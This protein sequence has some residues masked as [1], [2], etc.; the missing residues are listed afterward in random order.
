MNFRTLARTSCSVSSPSSAPSVRLICSCF[1][2]SSSLAAL[3]GSL[4]GSFAV[5]ALPVGSGVP[6]AGVVAR[7]E[8]SPR[9]KGVSNPDALA[10]ESSVQ[11]KGTYLSQW[12]GLQWAVAG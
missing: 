11:E 4:A 5:S 10:G 3:V 7:L 1:S 12:R 9:L 2:P 8:P 6:R